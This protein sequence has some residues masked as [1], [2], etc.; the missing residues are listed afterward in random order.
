MTWTLGTLQSE[1]PTKV[2]KWDGPRPLLS[3]AAGVELALHVCSVQLE[4]KPFQKLLPVCR[5][6]SS[7]WNTLTGLSWRGKAWPGKYF[8]CQGKGGYPGVS[9]PVQR[10]MEGEDYGSRKLGGEQQAG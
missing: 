2:Q 8:N 10:T 3:Y 5:M 1:S 9:P 6:C 4:W 7:S